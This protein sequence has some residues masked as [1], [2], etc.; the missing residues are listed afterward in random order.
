MPGDALGSPTGAVAPETATFALG[1]RLAGATRLAVWSTMLA[2]AGSAPNDSLVFVQQPQIDVVGGTFSLPVAIGQIYTVTTLLSAGRKGSFAPSPPPAAFPRSYADNFDDCALGAEAKYVT[3]F[4]GVMECVDSGDA[5]RGVVMQQVTPAAPIRW[6][7]DTRPHSVIGDA[8]W[9]DCAVSIDFQC[10]NPGGSAMLALRASLNG[11]DGPDGISAEDA[12]PGLWWSIGCAGGMNGAGPAVWNV[13]SSAGAVG[14][15]GAAFLTGTLAAPLAPGSWHSLHLVANGSQLSGWLDGAPVFSTSVAAAGAPSSGWAAFGTQRY[16]DFTFFD[17]LSINASA[18]RCSSAGSAGSPVAI[19]PCDAGAPG[20]QWQANLVGGGPWGTLS[21]SAVGGGAD[22][23][24]AV[25]K[26]KNQYG[27]FEVELAACDASL[28][29]E[30]LW[31]VNAA[32]STV[33][34]QGGHEGRPA[35]TNVCLDMTAGSY[36]PGTQL[37]VFPCQ[38]QNQDFALERGLLSGGDPHGFFCVGAC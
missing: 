34:T 20:Q 11:K 27:S 30:Q 29:P 10:N 31:A 9:S 19:W 2:V 33:T 36:S 17:S 16:G 5:A 3:D 8:T 7:T 18:S 22:L 23:C 13:T 26:T 12:L 37:D 6:W 4:N 25:A 32:N 21:L 24:L 1:G 35:G 14:N 38:L 15:A 28:P